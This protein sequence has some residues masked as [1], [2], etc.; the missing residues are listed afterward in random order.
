VK[1]R[2]VLI[3]WV[4]NELDALFDTGFNEFVAPGGVHGLARIDGDELE[5]L[6]VEVDHPGQ[7]HFRAFIAAAKEAFRVVRVLA[8]MN[9]GLYSVLQRYDFKPLPPENPDRP[10]PPNMEWQKGDECDV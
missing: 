8:I 6:A 2:E 9:Q 10:Y 7:G 5:V 1:A 3:S 4:P